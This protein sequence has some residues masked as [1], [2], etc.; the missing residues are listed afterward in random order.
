MGDPKKSKKKY[1]TPH[2]PWERDRME[3]ERVLRRDYGVKNKKEIWK[4]NAVL[5][6]FKD[7]TKKAAAL[8]GQKA[9]REKKQILEKLQALS[10][11]RPGQELD[12]VL[13]LTL[14]DIFE[15]RLQTLVYRKGLARSVKQA[16]QFIVH[17]HI[18]IADHKMTVPS[19][20]VKAQEEGAINFVAVSSLSDAGHPE[21]VPI[22][23]KERP[24]RK[25]KRVRQVRQRRHG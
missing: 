14:R 20:L 18:K 5:S 3:V 8:T 9:D 22:V 13:S 6:T 19:Y 21:R 4:M 16:R 2:H 10:L 7:R 25:V 11:I 17:G 12:A 24:T 15:R 1:A 23:R